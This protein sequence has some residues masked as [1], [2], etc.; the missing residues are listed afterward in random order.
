MDSSSDK[1]KIGLALGSGAA[2]GLAHIGVLQVLDEEGLAISAIAGTSIGALIGALYAAGVSTRDMEE[3]ARDVD[4]RKL[5]RL[6]DPIVP[7]SG[8]IDGKRIS[9]FFSEILP[10]RDFSELQIPMSMV[11]TDVESGETVVISRGD[12]HTALRAAISFPGILTPVSFGKRFLID[13]GLC[14][15][16]P[17]NIVRQMGVTEVIGVC[18]IPEVE[19]KDLKASLPNPNPP[20]LDRKNRF[21]MFNAERVERLWRDILGR[22]S[23]ETSSEVPSERRPPNLLRV[24]AQSIAIME[25][26]IN[27]L[28]L[29]TDQIDILIRPHLQGINLLDFHRADEIIRAGET[30]TREALPRIRKLLG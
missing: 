26:Q 12:L 23:K 24:F 28:R 14:H 5:A 6:V 2:R 10:V 19:K 13:G 7:T 3:V 22:K 4:W 30:A 18:A 21:G 25:N 29:A 1:K 27:E 16:V 9:R 11:T 17:T 20:P 8:F 15:P